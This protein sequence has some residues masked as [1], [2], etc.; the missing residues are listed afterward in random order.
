MAL[1]IIDTV[2]AGRETSPYLLTTGTTYSQITVGAGPTFAPGPPITFP[3]RDLVNSLRV[4]I[5]VTELSIF[6][7]G[8]SR[9]VAGS[10]EVSISLGKHMLCTLC[11]ASVL[12][13]DRDGPW[14]GTPTL[15]QN[16]AFFPTVIRWTFQR[17]LVVAPN[18]GF[19]GMA[20][21][22]T[23]VSP[24]DAAGAARIAMVARGRRLPAGTPVPRIRTIPYASGCFFPTAGVPAADFIFKNNFNTVLHVASINA[25]Q[26]DQF[27]IRQVVGFRPQVTITGP[28]GLS[29][30]VF[31]GVVPISS[32]DA[33]S[34]FS[35]FSAIRKEHDLE[36]DDAYQIVFNTLANN[37]A[38][39]P[40]AALVGWR[41]E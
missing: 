7:D 14:E 21:I 6:V 18:E 10:W 27:P 39:I 41:E 20:R 32:G 17:P 36:P 8:P 26:A 2:D 11:P 22:S 19:S 38:G 16:A 15:G 35:Q 24:L 34:I 30:S 25:R 4:P 29:G 40:A 28:G 23:S 12:G 13:I 1:N 33:A 31:R 9:L 5:E 3:T 37:P